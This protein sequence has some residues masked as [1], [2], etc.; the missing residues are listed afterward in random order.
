M[1]IDYTIAFY[2]RDS[3]ILT[4]RYMRGFLDLTPCR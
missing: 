4:F 3:S 1:C 2:I